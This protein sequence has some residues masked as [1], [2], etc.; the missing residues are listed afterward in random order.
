MTCQSVV[1]RN[2]AST[3]S[4]TQEA[5]NNGK[6]KAAQVFRRSAGRLIRCNTIAKITQPSQYSA[7]EPM[8]SML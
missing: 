7:G 2:R 6:S 8:S 1:L 5:M 3:C 4:G